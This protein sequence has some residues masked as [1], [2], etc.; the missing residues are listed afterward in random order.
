MNPS[1]Q[2]I[3]PRRLEEILSRFGGLRLVVIGDCMLDR[4]IWGA[5]E[6]I[7]PEAPVP[8]VR[9]K[10]ESVRLG[11]AA[12]VAANLVALGA[13]AQLFGVVG[14]DSAAREVRA[15][16]RERG[17]DD[18][19]VHADS[20]RPTT[21]KERVIAQSQQVVRI[22]RESGAEIAPDLVERIG[23]AAEAAL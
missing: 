12:N 23:A 17:I 6:R 5:V 10:R 1:L 15:A 3:S 13:R 8:I 20:S 21:V 4:Y 2:T 19:H 16:L 11:G 18:A 22:D 7:S 14:D 9:S